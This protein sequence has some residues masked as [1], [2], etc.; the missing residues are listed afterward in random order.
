MNGEHVI[1][2]TDRA[3]PLKSPAWHI[4]LVIVDGQTGGMRLKQV[5]HL[6]QTEALF[7]RCGANSKTMVVEGRGGT[8]AEACMRRAKEELEMQNGGSG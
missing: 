5:R 7:H 2:E 6:Q 4:R 3:S 1:W 8:W